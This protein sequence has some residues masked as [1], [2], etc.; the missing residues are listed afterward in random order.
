MKRFAV[1]I[2]MLPPDN[3]MDIAIAYN[4]KLMLSG[5][6]E[7]VLDKSRRMPHLSLLMGCLAAEQLQHANRTL[8]SIAGKHSVLNLNVANIRSVDSKSGETTVSLDIAPT[9]EL[10]AL[11]ESVVSHFVSLLTQDATASDMNDPPPIKASSLEWVNK[12]IP[13]ACFGNFWPHITLGMGE[14]SQNFE[15][16]SFQATRIA[17]CHLG[18]HCTCTEILAEERLHG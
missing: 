18:N 3:V 6:Q 2:V 12:F 7:I 8:R 15:P 1:D 11:H 5:N 14:L 16:F 17:V 9:P 4:R 10:L 13:D